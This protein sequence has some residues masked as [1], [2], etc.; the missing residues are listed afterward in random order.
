VLLGQAAPPA[1]DLSWQHAQEPVDAAPVDQAS[2]EVVAASSGASCTTS[3]ATA[4]TS[5]PRGPDRMLNKLLAQPCSMRLHSQQ[6]SGYGSPLPP[7]E[8][9]LI[10]PPHMQ[11]LAHPM[12]G[13]VQC[14]RNPTTQMQPDSGLHLEPGRPAH[15][16]AVQE[17]GS[18]VAPPMAPRGAHTPM[19]GSASVPIEAPWVYAARP[20]DALMASSRSAAVLPSPAQPQRL[21]AQPSRSDSAPVVGLVEPVTVAAAAA[22]PKVA[23]AIEPV[24][25]A[26]QPSETE[27][28]SSA[29]SPTFASALNGFAD[30]LE[31]GKPVRDWTEDDVAQWLMKLSTV[32]ADILDVVHLHAISG[33]V[34]LSLTEEDLEALRIEKFGHRRLLLLAAQELRRAVQV[35]VD[36]PYNAVHGSGRGVADFAISPTSSVGS[37]PGPAYS[38][39][40]P[41][42]RVRVLSPSPQL[43]TASVPVAGGFMMPVARQAS[44]PRSWTPQ[45]PFTMGRQPIRNSGP[46]VMQRPVQGNPSVPPHSPPPHVRPQVLVAVSRQ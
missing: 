35:P 29:W 31:V 9:M 17:F 39:S 8:A 28:P 44:V 42:G 25:V 36:R 24:A 23:T 11:T 7:Q 10:A 46:P 34:L 38:V 32:P 43:G 41:Q 2:L 26:V 1:E 14:C 45:V 19:S 40:A 6:R 5:A 21:L 22:E 16:E 30:P 27:T 3:A 18:W 13:G 4:S 37:A 12:Q 33:A 20:R 15:F